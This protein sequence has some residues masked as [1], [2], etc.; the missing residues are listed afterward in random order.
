MYKNWQ[1]EYKDPTTAEECEEIRKFYKPYLEKYESKYRILYHILQQD[2]K[3][4]EQTCLLSRQ[5][6][7]S[8]VTPSLAV[9]DDAQALRQKEWQRGEPGE[10][11]PRQYSSI[12]GHLT[13]ALPRKEDMRLDSTLNVTPKGSLDNL[14]AAVGGMEEAKEETHQISEKK[15][16]GGPSTDV[17]TS[18][19]ETHETLLKVT[20]ENYINVAESSRRIQRSREVSREDAIA[21][22]RHFFAS[23]NKRNRSTTIEGLIE[24]SPVATGRNASNVPVVSTSTTAI[25]TGTETTEAEISNTRTFLSNGSPSRPTVTATCQP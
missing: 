5:E 24:T 9:L 17:R 14:P 12:S 2:N 20:P 18:I 22:T 19:E 1:A 7:D 16:Q 25:V 11:M 13:P 6:P 8:G 15:I 23:V 4:V 3:L 21:S 10:D